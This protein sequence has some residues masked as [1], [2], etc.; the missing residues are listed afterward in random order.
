MRFKRIAPCRCRC[1]GR[2]HREHDTAIGTCLDGLTAAVLEPP[3]FAFLR[4]WSVSRSPRPPPSASSWSS[5]S[6]S[7]S[8]ARLAARVGVS[9]S[10]IACRFASICAAVHGGLYATLG[11]S[12]HRW[13]QFRSP[14]AL[15]AVP[16]ADVALA[17]GNTVLH[18]AKQST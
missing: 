7:T 5:S 15:L 12:A 13:R 14:L 8:R 4:R 9:W 1:C 11:D 16:R 6:E 18:C 3:S 10:P 2:A 17:R